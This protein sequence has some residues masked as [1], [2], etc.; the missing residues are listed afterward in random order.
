MEFNIR[1]AGKSVDLDALRTTLG[2]V[3]PTAMVDLDRGGV[4]RIAIEA[5]ARDLAGW[6]Q[7]AGCEVKSSQILEVPAFCCGG[8]GG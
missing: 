5:S 2:G 4:L 1:M 6:L 8:C 7:N 3:D